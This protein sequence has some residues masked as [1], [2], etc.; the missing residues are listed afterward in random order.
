MVSKKHRFVVGK[1]GL[2]SHDNGLR[3]IS[4]WLMDSGYEVVYAGLYNTTRRLV[5]MALQEDANAI[6]ISSLGGE[7][8]YYAAELL[9]ELKENDMGHVKVIMGGVIPPADV[10]ELKGLGVNAVFTPGTMR[11]KILKD[12]DTLFK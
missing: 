12:I 5:Q 11:D 8:L 7:H 10:E 1:L 2:D 3:I 9:K 4:K 6:G